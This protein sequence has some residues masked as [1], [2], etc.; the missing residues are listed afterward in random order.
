[1][2]IEQLQTLSLA[3]YIAAAVFL[4]VAIVLFFTLRVPQL[5]NDVTGRSQKRAIAAFQSQGHGTSGSL[6]NEPTQV[7]NISG[8]SR[9]K[10]KKLTTA[11]LQKNGETTAQLQNG[12]TVLPGAG[13]TVLPGAGTSVLGAGGTAFLQPNGTT[14]LCA[15]DPGTTFLQMDAQQ[16]TV[17]GPVQLPFSVEFELSFLG[18]EE[19][20][21]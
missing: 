17:G 10:E 16:P 6:T 12:T 21:V 8:K 7:R 11:K 1:M 3:L 13:T 20:I 19:R 15:G 2:S 4:V 5:F 18:S 9:R 14:V